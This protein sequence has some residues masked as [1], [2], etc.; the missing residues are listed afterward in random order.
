MR[1]IAENNFYRITLWSEF[2]ITHDI[3]R[4]VV[5]DNDPIVHF[6]VFALFEEHSFMFSVHSVERLQFILDWQSRCTWMGSK[7]SAWRKFS[8]NRLEWL[9]NRLTAVPK[10]TTFIRKKQS[11]CMGNKRSMSFCAL[12]RSVLI[13][14]QTAGA[15]NR[16]KRLQV[17][18]SSL[19]VQ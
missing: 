15:A 4:W 19:T 11:L 17:G 7:I 14:T 5:H 3:F 2:N 6:H 13:N 1:S 16:A 10:Y 12:S 8:R 9:H 18:H